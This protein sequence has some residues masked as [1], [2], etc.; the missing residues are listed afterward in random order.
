MD[1]ASSNLQTEGQIAKRMYSSVVKTLYSRAENMAFEFNTEISNGK[2]V[3][4]V[5]GE[6]EGK[7]EQNSFVETAYVAAD[8]TVTSSSDALKAAIAGQE[9]VEKAKAGTTSLSSSVKTAEGLRFLTAAPTDNGGC[10]VFTLDGQY[11]SK[12][13]SDISVEKTGNIFVIDKNGTM[14]AN[15]RPQLVEEQQN[16][17]EMAKTDKKYE[18]SAAVYQKMIA[19]EEG[20]D[21]YTYDGATRIC[22]YGPITYTDGWSYGVVI[23][24]KELSEYVNS[25][26]VTLVVCA[27]VCMVIGC[28]SML[29]FTGKMVTPL[30]GIS[31]AMK[32]LAQ[33]D[34]STNVKIEKRND[35]VG[36]LERDFN[37]TVDTLRSYIDDISEVLQTMASGDFTAGTKVQYNGEFTQIKD[38]ID[39]ILGSLNDSFGEITNAAN[40]VTQGSQQV[41]ESAQA[42]SQGATKQASSIQ[43]L[44]SNVQDISAHIHT[45][46][47]HTATANQRVAQSYKLMESCEQHMEGMKSTMDEINHNSQEIARLSALS[48]I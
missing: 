6:I 4:V 21:R 40:Q 31:G 38:S 37:T 19:G 9:C 25:I 3:E 33:G 5:L 48:K 46:T 13:I 35:E 45:T 18:T 2:A 14:I 29:F 23:P 27:L 1:C 22:A 41:S 20:F 16:F 11:F 36:D 30:V 10:L 39:T 32:K 43:E 34:L 15:F 8:G 26:V 42:L 17:I 28:I 12:F 7:L 24:K 47:E 44:A